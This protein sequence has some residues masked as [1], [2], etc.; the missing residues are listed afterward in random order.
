MV[1]LF[2]FNFDRNYYVLKSKRQCILLNININFKKNET[3]SKIEHPTHS[4]RETNL[5][6]QS[7]KIKN[8]T[9][10]SWSSRNKTRAFL[11]SFILLKGHFL[12]LGFYLTENTFRIYI[13]LHIKKHY[14]IHF[15]C[16]FF[17]SLEAFSE[18]LRKNSFICVA[19][20]LINSK[21]KHLYKIY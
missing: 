15:C 6:L 3:E 12:A 1:F 10:M 14:F 16:W 2:L 8:K 20:C 5:V 4:F 7:I 21:F 17:K 18:S 13:L 11:L 19:A 9:V